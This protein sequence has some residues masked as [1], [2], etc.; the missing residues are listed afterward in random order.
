MANTKQILNR[1]NVIKD[2]LKITNAMY[3]IS[4][5]KIKK[6]QKQLE[7][8]EIYFH[9]LQQDI[10][11]L[12][13]HMPDFS[14]RYIEN[15]AKDKPEKERTRGYIVITADKGMSGAYN[16]NAIKLAEQDMQR[17]GKSLLFSVGLVGRNYFEKKGY[18]EEQHFQYTVQNPSIHRA[19]VI[20]EYILEYYEEHQIDEIYIVYT[21]VAHGGGECEAQMQRL[22][23]LKKSDFVNNS[24]QMDNMEFY[25][26]AHAIFRKM[27]PNYITGFIYGALVESFCSEHTCRVAAMEAATDNAKEMLRALSLQYNRVRQSAITQEITEVVGGAKAQRKKKEKRG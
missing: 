2:T 20:S 24:P 25:P 21:R 12:I 22:L 7:S 1:M 26:G 11:D 16:I 6:A 23:P 10:W 8:G 5:A 13:S 19:R 9:T 4:S 14:S 15:P 27:I 18:A 3:M 17:E